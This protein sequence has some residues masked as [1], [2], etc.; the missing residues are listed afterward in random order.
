MSESSFEDVIMEDHTPQIKDALSRLK[1][2]LDFSQEI[3]SLSQDNQQELT[4]DKF[5]DQENIYIK[6]V[7]FVANL[8]LKKAIMERI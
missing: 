4:Y 6:E 1:S 8:A 7:G 2:G 5:Q 3:L